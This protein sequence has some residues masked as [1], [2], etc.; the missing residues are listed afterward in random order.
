MASLRE[1]G[2]R[3]T[4]AGGERGFTLVELLLV[5]V[6]MSILSAIAI[7]GMGN[8]SGSSSQSACQTTFRSV[9]LA[10]EAYK[11]QMGGYPN[12]TVAN[13]GTNSLPPTDNDLSTQNAAAA[14]TGPGSELLV[15]GNTVPNT[16]ASAATGGPWLKDL[17][18]GLGHYWLSV[19][20]DGTG[21]ISVYNKTNV[22]QGNL[23]S[24]CP[25]T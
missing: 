16:V 10:V 23:S 12:A 6:I 3:H 1:P 24:N 5:I 11:S 20:N 4:S 13:G 17:P 19:S 15:T 25:T 14:V 18:I 8:L 21:T 7:F 9:Q 22:L 2:S